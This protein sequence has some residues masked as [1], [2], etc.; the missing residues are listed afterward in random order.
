MF[1]EQRASRNPSSTP[2]R[3]TPR[4]KIEGVQ[5]HGTARPACTHRCGTT[6]APSHLPASSPKG[7]FVEKYAYFLEI[8][9]SAYGLFRDKPPW[10]ALHAP[11]SLAAGARGSTLLP[12]PSSVRPM[13]L[14]V[15]SS[16]ASLCYAASLPQPGDRNT[17]AKRGREDSRH[18]GA[19]VLRRTTWSNPARLGVRARLKLLF[20]LFS[21]SIKHP[22]PA[23]SRYQFVS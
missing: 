3:D 13:Q 23:V 7:E 18:G 12:P 11:A 1:F 9:V 20:D 14:H 19:L 17:A 15:C 22:Q 8:L 10:F 4:G 16:Y 21:G 5:G 6:W 2:R